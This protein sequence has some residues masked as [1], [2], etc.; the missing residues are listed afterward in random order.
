[1]AGRKVLIIG[2]A[3]FIGCNS[4]VAFCEAGDRVVVF[5]NLSRRGTL[6][7]LEWIQSLHQIDF[8][9]GDICEPHDLAG[10]FSAHPDID[11]I[12]HLAAQTAVTTSIEN[13][14]EDFAINALGTLNILESVRSQPS[15]PAL[16]Y[17]STNKVYGGLDNIAVSEGETRYSF[18]DLPGGVVESQPLDFHSPY[19][20]SKGTA[21]QYVHDYSRIYGMPTIV[22]R[23]SCI[24]GKR[25]FGIE[26]QGWVAW[27]LAALVGGKNIA[28]YG[29]GKQVRDLLYVDDLARAYISALDCL[30][31]TI[32]QVYNIGGGPANSI[33]VWAEFQPLLAK[34]TGDEVEAE[35][36][37]WRPGDQRIFIADIDKAK[38]EFGW[39]PQISVEEGVTRLYEWISA[40]IDLF[41]QLRIMS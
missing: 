5:D 14:R 22:F 4:A 23:Q 24:Y 34:L 39:A 16:I 13:P 8:Y 17:A 32:G 20:C 37:D 15:S 7:N 9:R 18:T 33:S 26:D 30:D 41:K 12:L 25:Q 38:C 2:G 28:V 6:E 11:A 1:M 27:F 3:G 35:R 10:V 19:G 21:D 29:D 36:R 40:H 31:A